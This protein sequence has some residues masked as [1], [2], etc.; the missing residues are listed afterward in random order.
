MYNSSSPVSIFPATFQQEIH[1]LGQISGEL[2]KN[3]WRAT[4]IDLLLTNLNTKVELKPLATPLPKLARIMNANAKLDA[5][6]NIILQI[7]WPSQL[8]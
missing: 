4:W 7:T 2:G 3:A 1:S 5:N 8:N 6:L